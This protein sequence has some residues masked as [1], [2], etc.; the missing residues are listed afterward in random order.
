MDV[1]NNKLKI[2]SFK[3]KTDAL[4]SIAE[5]ARRCL[6]LCAQPDVAELL[7][8]ILDTAEVTNELYGSN[9][10]MV[11]LSSSLVSQTSKTNPYMNVSELLNNLKF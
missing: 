5:L 8:G 1:L 6:S 10:E 3:R 9:S 2:N 4:D 11:E 7:Q